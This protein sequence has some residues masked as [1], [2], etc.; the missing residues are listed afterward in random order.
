MG[1]WLRQANDSASSKQAGM[2]GTVEL[3]DINCTETPDGLL[4]VTG[5]TVLGGIP[6][7]YVHAPDGNVETHVLPVGAVLLVSEGDS[8]KKGDQLWK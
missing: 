5:S 6:T 3:H 2:N 1:K 7:L 8:C 4:R